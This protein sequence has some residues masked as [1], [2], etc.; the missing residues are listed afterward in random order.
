MAVMSCLSHGTQDLYPDFLK[1]V[2]HFSNATISALAIVYNCSAIAGALCIGGLSER[3]GRRKSILLAF[4]VA[5]LALPAWAFGG[6]YAALLAGSVLMQ[7]G[8]QG[9]FGVIPAHLNE[10]SP[11]AIR[12]LFPGF[13]YQLG[14]LIGSPAVT[15]EYVLRDHIGY[16]WALVLFELCVLVLLF[17]LFG[18]GPE[19]RGRNFY[20]TDGN[21]N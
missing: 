4:G 17:F 7:F 16:E 3:V 20:T 8:V 13:V 5:L 15:I 1:S 14:V 6:G 21:G 11:P 9:A 18:F 12:S 2:H 10:L 19:Q